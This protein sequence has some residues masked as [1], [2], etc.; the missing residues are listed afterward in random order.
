MAEYGCNSIIMTNTLNVEI[1]RLWVHKAWENTK[2][3]ILPCKTCYLFSNY[4][5]MMLFICIY[6]LQ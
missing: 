1:E 2:Y 5:P 3:F 4:V 6:V